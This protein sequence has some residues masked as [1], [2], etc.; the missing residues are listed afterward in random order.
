M[1]GLISFFLRLIREDGRR[2]RFTAR[3]HYGVG[4]RRRRRFGR[5]GAGQGHHAAIRGPRRGLRAPR[6]GHRAAAPGDHAPTVASPSAP[7]AHAGEEIPGPMLA[8]PTRIPPPP[9]APT[10]EPGFF[11]F[12]PFPNGAGGT[13]QAAGPTPVAQPEDVDAGP[14]RS[15]TEHP[16][17]S[18]SVLDEAPSSPR[19]VARPRLQDSA[20]ME[21]RRRLFSRAITAIDRRESSHSG[22][23]SDLPNGVPAGVVYISSSEEE[24]GTSAT[25]L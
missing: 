12:V 16:H 14:S 20:S 4:G 24:G 18:T 9:P 2:R 15:A 25:T 13:I 3:G 8:A 1:P 19:A 23:A 22:L 11:V 5:R 17:A 10:D 21:G 6:H 7:P